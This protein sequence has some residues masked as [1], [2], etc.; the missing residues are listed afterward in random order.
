[1]ETYYS[2][3]WVLVVIYGS[4]VVGGW[5]VRSGRELVGVFFF[6]V[7]G[8]LFGVSIFVGFDCIVRFCFSVGGMVEIYI[9]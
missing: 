6:V 1:M 9:L 5:V 3:I 4:R 2:F 8:V 7:N